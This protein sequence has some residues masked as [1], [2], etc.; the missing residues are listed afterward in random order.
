MAKSAA[1][2][3]A[4]L[5][6]GKTPAL[7]EETDAAVGSGLVKCSPCD[8]R[9]GFAGGLQCRTCNGTGKHE[10]VEPATWIYAMRREN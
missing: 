6:S 2:A 5:R 8:G 7:P 4:D 3:L 10:P 9:G 1:E